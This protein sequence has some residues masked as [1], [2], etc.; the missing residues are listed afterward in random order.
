VQ[1]VDNDRPYWSVLEV[2]TT[3]TTKSVLTMMI[4]MMVIGDTEGLEAG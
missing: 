2:T 4:M 1:S 3:T